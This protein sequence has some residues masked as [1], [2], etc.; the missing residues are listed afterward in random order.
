MATVISNED[1]SKC[2]FKNFPNKIARLAGLSLHDSCVF[3]IGEVVRVFT[4]NSSMEESQE[5]GY[6]FRF[7]ELR[8]K[9]GSGFVKLGS[10]RETDSESDKKTKR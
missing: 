3:V 7:V 4:A 9:S 5:D 6:S 10:E 8:D 1:A 2:E